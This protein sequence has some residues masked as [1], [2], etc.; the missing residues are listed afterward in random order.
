MELQVEYLVQLGKTRRGEVRRREGQAGLTHPP[1]FS[2]FSFS[3]QFTRMGG[4]SFAVLPIALVP[5]VQTTYSG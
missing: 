2:C 3:T 4:D 1:A 5:P